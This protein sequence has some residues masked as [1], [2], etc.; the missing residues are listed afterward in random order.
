MMDPGKN[1][2]REKELFRAFFFLRYGKIL[3]N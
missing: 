1:F 3:S 2:S